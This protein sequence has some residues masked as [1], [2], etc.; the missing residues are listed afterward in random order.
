VLLGMRKRMALIGRSSR[1]AGDSH[2][3]GSGRS[4]IEPRAVL[5]NNAAALGRR[6]NVVERHQPRLWRSQRSGSSRV[7]PQGGIRRIPWRC[8]FRQPR[9]SPRRT[10]FSAVVRDII[11]RSSNRM[12]R[13]TPSRRA[14]ATGRA[15]RDTTGSRHSSPREPPARCGAP[16]VDRLAAI[17]AGPS[18]V[19][20][21]FAVAL[22]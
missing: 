22:R 6:R 17:A 20:T 9:T 10:A 4:M 7:R 5:R 2:G 15:A 13:V 16:G 14:L 3:R 8:R 12:R 18:Y 11:R 21:P 19:R 1:P